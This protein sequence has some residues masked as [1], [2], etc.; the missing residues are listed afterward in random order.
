VY[1]Q[2]IGSEKKTLKKLPVSTKAVLI[3][4]DGHIL[5]MRKSNGIV[6][7]PGG[8]VEEGEDLFETLNREVE[9][10]TGLN[11]ERFEFVASWVKHHP[12]LGDRL[13]VVFEA[14]IKTK[15]K[16]TPVIMSPEHGWFDFICPLTVDEIGDMPPGYGN[17]ISICHNRHQTRKAKKAKAKMIA[18][19]AQ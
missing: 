12:T 5:L 18:K 1:W 11:V 2:Q 3:T 4:K 16:K 8:K 6:D 14:R 7:L 15:A 10:E 9:E 13:V 17:A 19:A